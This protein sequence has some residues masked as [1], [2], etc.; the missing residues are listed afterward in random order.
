MI[1]N[2]FFMV[3]VASFLA[4]VFLKYLDLKD[5]VLAA[6]VT[7]SLASLCNWLVLKKPITDV[8]IGLRWSVL[9]VIVAEIIFIVAFIQG[10]VASRMFEPVFNWFSATLLSSGSIKSV[11]NDLGGLQDYHK[12]IFLCIALHFSALV[13]AYWVNSAKPG[14]TKTDYVIGFVSIV[15]VFLIG[16]LDGFEELFSIA[17]SPPLDF[18]ISGVGPLFVAVFIFLSIIPVGVAYQSI[19]KFISCNFFISSK[20]F[21]FVFL[22]ALF[23]KDNEQ[24]RYLI[25]LF[26]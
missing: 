24:V 3:I 7:L 23:L 17:V 8:T 22:L 19:S 13:I 11:I 26:F 16:K 6:Y 1:L 2:I 15:T 12:I 4:S 20:I 14:A 9:L 25:D 10:A 18:P 5:S 21:F